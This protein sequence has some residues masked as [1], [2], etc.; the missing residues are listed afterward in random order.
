M[1]NNIKISKKIIRITIIMI[2]TRISKRM[3]K[4][5]RNRIKINNGLSKNRDRLYRKILVIIKSI[6]K[7]LNKIWS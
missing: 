4:N 3:S 6:L 7:R 2:N 5:K 1:K